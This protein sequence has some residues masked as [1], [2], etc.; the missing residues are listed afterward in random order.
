VEQAGLAALQSERCSPMAVLACA[1]RHLQSGRAVYLDQNPPPRGLAP[2]HE[3]LRDKLVKN[4][5]LAP[6]AAPNVFRLRPREA[7]EELTVPSER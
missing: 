7:D 4:F 1:Q 2:L 5:R 6:T 3:R